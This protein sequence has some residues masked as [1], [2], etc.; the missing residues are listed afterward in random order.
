MKHSCTNCNE[1]YETKGLLNYVHKSLH[2]QTVEV[3]ENRIQSLEV[4]LTRVIDA[5]IDE[6][7]VHLTSGACD[8][9]C[10]ICMAKRALG[11]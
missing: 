2:D 1:I 7:E 5:H 10:P 11:G 3:L 6:F 8:E 4:A 9:D